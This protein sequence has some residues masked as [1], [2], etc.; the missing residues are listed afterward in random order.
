MSTSGSLP[1]RAGAPTDTSNNCSLPVQVNVAGATSDRA[2]LETFY[3]A[4]GGPNWTRNDNW[5]SGQPLSTWH[6]VETDASGRVKFLLLLD[7][8]LTGQ[9]PEALGELAS[10]EFLDLGSS[11]ISASIANRHGL[12]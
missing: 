12:K 1:H 3:N 7:N 10:L 9:I 4:I 8:N 5:L 11:S 6:G 2:V